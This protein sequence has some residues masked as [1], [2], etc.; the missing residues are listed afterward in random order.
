MNYSDEF[1]PTE[2][3]AGVHFYTCAITFHINLEMIYLFINLIE[4]SNSKRSNIIIGC[5]YRHPNMG[6]DEFNDNYLNTLLHKISKEN[7]SV[8]LLSDFNVD[9]L[10]YDKHAPINEFLDSLSSHMFLPHIVQPARINTTSKTLTDNIFSNIHT[11]SSVSGNLTSSISD[12]LPQF[13]IVP[14]TFLNSSPPKSNIYE[15]DR[16]NF[17]QENFV[18]DYLAVDWTIIIKSENK[19]IDFSFGCFLKKFNLILDKYLLLKKLT[20]QKLKF[21]TKLWITPSLQKSVLVKNKLLAKFIKLKEP[22]LKNEAH[23]KYNLYRNMLAT[24]LKRS[25]HTYFSYFFQNHINDLKNTLKGV[26]RT[27]SLKDSTSTVPS[28]IT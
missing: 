20:K 24:L 5:I 26:K 8:F 27:I 10:K 11:P 1:C 4:I 17:D 22:T 18:L 9:L 21:K 28:T 14:D 15:R 7:K 12:H 2:S 23:I 3:L 19:N 16:N 25:K 6:L 13:L